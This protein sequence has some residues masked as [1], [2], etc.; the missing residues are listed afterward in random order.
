MMRAPTRFLLLLVFPA[1]LTAQSV[2]RVVVTPANPTVVAGETLQLRA[3][4]LDAS[5]RPVS[6]ATIRFQQT[7][8]QFEGTVTP[9]GLVSAGAVGS[10]PVVVSAVVGTDK[11]V[12]ARIEVRQVPGPASTIKVSPGVS[13]LLAG[14]TVALKARVL[15]KAGDLRGD[16]VTWSTSAPNVARVDGIG[17]LTGFAPGEATITAKVGTVTWSEKVTVLASGAMT[18]TLS[19]ASPT[20]RTGDVIRFKLDVKGTGGAEVAGLAPTWV[21][22]PGDGSID[23]DGAFVGY[24]AGTYT[25]IAS[26]GQRSAQ[27]TVTLTPRD[28]RRPAQVLGSVVR[29]AFPTSEV[30]VHPTAPVAYLGTH[31]GGDRVYVLDVGDVSKPTIIDSVMLNARVI[32]DVMT[33]EDGKVLVITRE[34]A[35]D[36]KNG[37]VIYTLDDPRH[38]KKAGEFTDGVT[39]GVHSAYVY[40]QQR[41]GRHVYLTNDGTGALHIIDINDPTKPKEVAQWKTPRS[42]AGRSLHDIDVRDGMVYA[43]YWNDGL[44]VLDVGKGTKGGSPSN[45]QVVSQF[46]YDLQALYK[47]VEAI[48]GP[49]YIRGTHT[50]WRHKDYVFIA[51]EVFTMSDI[52]KLSSK[53]AARAFG[54]LQVV[55]VKDPA[56]PKS[57]AWYEPEYGGVHNIWIAG[58]TLYM[59]AYN[60]GFRAFDISGEL[61]GD[62]RAQQREITNYMPMDPKGFIPNTTMTWG[63]VVKD[64]VAYVND[65]NTGLSLVRIAP[66]PTIVP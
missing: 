14:Q 22:A 64:G 44:V 55:D 41:F 8:G 16:A 61:R 12:I 9:D 10:F 53:N 34:G 7:G 5:G 1:V 66:K 18:L 65:F 42:D 54:R 36:R 4:A 63:V 38:P 39:A 6:G 23:S 50:A 19:P 15:S 60:A 48:D 58:D 3:Q 13:K 25:V 49:G 31:L 45:P 2:S 24:E 62:L 43:S 33:S 21:I 11:P 57:V 37:I 46:K 17:T 40:T 32:N 27:A 47:Q 30:W 51:D 59:G 52:Q 28:V 56:N 20:A 35:D 29:T 26:L